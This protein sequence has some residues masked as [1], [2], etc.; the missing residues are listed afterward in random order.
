MIITAHGSRCIN[1]SNVATV[2]GLSSS[3]VGSGHT[4]LQD[5]IEGINL[6]EYLL[7]NKADFKQRVG[8]LTLIGSGIRA[9]HSANLVHGKISLQNVIV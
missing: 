7:K 8:I 1:E 6:E 4:L 2:K 3:N 5:Y 9:F